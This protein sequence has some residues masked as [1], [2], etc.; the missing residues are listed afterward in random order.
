ME[1]ILAPLDGSL[2]GEHALPVALAIARRSGATLALAHTHQLVV[3]ATAPGGAPGFDLTFDALLREQEQSYLSEVADRVAA[4]WAGPVV[5]TLL[6][7]PLLS[8]LSDFAHER[9]AALIVMSSHRRSDLPEAWLGG[10]ADRLIRKA[11][12]P[13]LVVH[14][15]DGEPD[16]AAEPPLRHILVPLDGSALAEGAL[17]LATRIG[18]LFGA[19]YTLLQAVAPILRSSLIDGPEPAVDT[20]A[21]AAAWHQAAAYLESAAAPLRE[22]GCEVLTDAVIGS[23]ATTIMDY[24]RDYGVDLIAMSTHGRGG[25]ARLLLGSVAG[26]VLH[27]TA[28]AAL[29]ERPA[30]AHQE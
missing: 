29:I 27:R 24:A 26:E 6:E 5:S 30:V 13:I 25:L 16:L 2:F 23:P 20:E 1:T 15:G 28:T 8:S 10:V 4:V 18:R 11:A 12:V 14:P 21:Q 9:G 7:A 22:Q 17:A 19:R 3:P